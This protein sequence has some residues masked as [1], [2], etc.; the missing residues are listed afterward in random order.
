VAE[1]AQKFGKVAL[2]LRT[3]LNIFVCK[4]LLQSFGTLANFGDEQLNNVHQY[5]I[6]L[7]KCKI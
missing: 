3:I 2:K 1:V 5:Y 6:G 7:M 4:I